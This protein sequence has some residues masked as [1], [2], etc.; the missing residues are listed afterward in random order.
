V[1]YVEN[2]FRAALFNKTEYMGFPDDEM[3]KRWSDL[4]NGKSAKVHIYYQLI[5]ILQLATQ[6]YQKRKQENFTLQ[7]FQFPVPK[8]TLFNLTFGMSFTASMISGWFCTP[9]DSAVLIT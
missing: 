4:Y 2:H 7:L 6:S 9:N 3:D 1:E 5:T 8:T